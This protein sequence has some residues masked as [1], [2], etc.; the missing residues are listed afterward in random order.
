MEEVQ[1]PG[2]GTRGGPSGPGGPGG[3]GAS[4]QGTSKMADTRTSNLLTNRIEQEHS[5]SKVTITCPVNTADYV[6]GVMLLTGTC[7]G[8]QGTWGAK[9]F[10]SIFAR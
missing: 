1:R 2:G 8:F 5:N 7:R 3:R 10:C 4:P 9:K 6:I